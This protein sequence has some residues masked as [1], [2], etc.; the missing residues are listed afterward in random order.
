[1][2]VHEQAEVIL[3]RLYTCLEKEK[4]CRLL[5]RKMDGVTYPVLRMLARDEHHLA[6][7]SSQSAKQII[8]SLEVA[9][10]SPTY[11]HAFDKRQLMESPWL[12]VQCFISVPKV[13]EAD[14]CCD[15]MPQYSGRWVNSNILRM[16]IHHRL[17]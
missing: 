7:L 3:Q 14:A 15:T 12:G 11:R 10:V 1:M 5:L 16:C 17:P 6:A 8:E 9:Q 13:Y 4:C 2:G